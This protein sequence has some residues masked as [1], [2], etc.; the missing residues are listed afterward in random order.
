[1]MFTM[2]NN[3]AVF[4]RGELLENLFYHE[5]MEES[6]GIYHIVHHFHQKNLYGVG[7][8]VECL[9]HF[10]VTQRHLGKN[11]VSMLLPETL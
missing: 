7:A 8:Q 10:E 11:A 3:T 9:L 1:M 4:L 2:M 5:Y 6:V